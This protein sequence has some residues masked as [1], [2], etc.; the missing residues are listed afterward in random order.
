MHLNHYDLWVSVVKV[1]LF[2]QSVFVP[3]IIAKSELKPLK[4][5]AVS[6]NEDVKAKTFRRIF[7]IDEWEEKFTCIFI[8]LQ[9]S[10]I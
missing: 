9:A 8:T 1:K 3:G 5:L 6:V 2:K 7:F 4:S 10:K